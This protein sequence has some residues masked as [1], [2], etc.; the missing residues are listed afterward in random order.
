MFERTG[1]KEIGRHDS[2]LRCAIA[3][4]AKLENVFLS[5]KLEHF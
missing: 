1:Q 3:E 5:T 4:K 2:E